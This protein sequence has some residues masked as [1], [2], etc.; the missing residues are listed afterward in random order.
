MMLLERTLAAGKAVLTANG[1]IVLSTIV[2][3]Q[4][5]GR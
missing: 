4:A 2:Q 5:T 1:V 3:A